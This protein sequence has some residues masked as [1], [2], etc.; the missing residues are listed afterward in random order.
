MRLSASLVRVQLAET[1]SPDSFLST[2]NAQSLEGVFVGFNSKGRLVVAD[3][4][5]D[6]VKSV[7]RWRQD[8]S[9]VKVQTFD[10]A[11]DETMQKYVD[12]LMRQ[13]AVT[14]SPEEEAPVS[15]FAD[16]QAVAGEAQ[17]TLALTKMNVDDVLEEVR[18]YLIADG[19][20]VKVVAV[21]DVAQTVTLS[22]QGACGS[23]PSSTTTMKMGIER[24]LRENFPLLKEVLSVADAPDT[25]QLSK[26]AVEAA[27]AKITPAIKA[28]K[29]S[30]AVAEVDAASG[31]VRI[32]F[33]GP[34]K[35]KQ[36]VELVIKDVP[37]VQQVIIEDVV[38]LQ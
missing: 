9:Q 25:P 29:G 12:E 22:L 17:Q 28:L 26:E 7:E 38:E 24:V 5:R 32:Q 11:T 10:G 35:L 21:D 37:L 36:G 16:S 33:K 14:E 3:Y 30:V 18:P 2:F 15:P 34:A 6:L 27:L 23:C 13:M 8:I 31:S 4:S 20:N 19:G 1:Y